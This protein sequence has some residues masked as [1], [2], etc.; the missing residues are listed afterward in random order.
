MK[1]VQYITSVESSKG[2]V[3]TFISQLSDALGL[4]CDLT[5]IT[6][7]SDKPKVQLTHCEVRYVSLGWWHLHR[8]AA[9]FGRVLDEIRPDIVQINGIW[10]IQTWWIQKEAIKRGIPTLIMPHGMLEPWIMQ[11]HR[12][13]KKLGMMLYEKRALSQAKCLISTSEM[14]TQSLLKG[15]YNNC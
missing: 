10:Q 6:S 13:K 4:L 14:E 5:I 3:S 8:W 1:V 7:A 12:W 15:N 11:R 9:E 2:G